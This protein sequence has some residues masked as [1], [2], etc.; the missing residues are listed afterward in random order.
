MGVKSGVMGVKSGVVGVKS[1]AV[2]VKSGAEG[3]IS[4]VVA[5]GQKWCLL[6]YKVSRGVRWET[7]IMSYDENGKN[8]ENDEN[9][10]FPRKR[11]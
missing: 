9:Y 5:R 11:L 4:G 8:Y 10:E 7:L 2:G 6:S 1:G 3:V